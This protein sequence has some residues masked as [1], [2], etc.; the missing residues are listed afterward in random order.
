MKVLQ[1]LPELNAGGVERGTLELAHHLVQ[2][3][4]TALVVSHG[5]KL[6]A[7]LTAAGAHHVIL[8]VHRKSLRSLFQILPLKKLLHRERP[9]VVHI[10]SRVPGWIT[11]FAW[12]MLP[13]PARPR[14]VSTV[15]GFYSVN[16]YSAIMTR[17]ERVIAVSEA[18]RTYI[19]QHYP[20]TP[21]A[22]I[23]VI[24]RGIDPHRFHTAFRPA[25]EWEHQ[26]QREFPHLTGKT[27]ITLPGRITR[28]K[29]HETFLRL[30]RDLR[31]EFPQLHALIVGDTHAKK[32]DYRTELEAHI[33]AT[34]LQDHVTFT[35]HRTDLREILAHS[36][37]S[38]SLSTQPEAFGRTVLEA[39]A[40]GRPVLGYDVG[41]AGELLHQF[42]PAGIIPPND[43]SA[44]LARTRDL[45]KHP[46][47]PRPITA[48]Y[49]TAAMC[50]RTEAVY[51][52]LV[53]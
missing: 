40:L 15:H 49:T 18:I 50:A 16:A 27:L 17:G 39:L 2:A 22:Q 53:P 8:P 44:L 19:Q 31:P 52:E 1:I 41:G 29:G 20:R 13:P 7:E 43:S 6:V 30:V 36:A 9:D 51:R 32:H 34:G 25:P 35:G 11:W 3:G 23:R 37:L 26:W 42:F 48:A 10:R 24:P 47:S 45:L 14:L 38:F 33:A 4:H 28:L 5:G 21:A 46:A 12:H